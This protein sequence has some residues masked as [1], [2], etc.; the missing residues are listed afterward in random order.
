MFI[1]GWT[2]PLIFI[3]Q[4]HKQYDS[5]RLFS[6]VQN[7]TFTDAMSFKVG[8]FNNILSFHMTM[9]AEHMV[10]NMQ[11]FYEKNKC[12]ETIYTCNC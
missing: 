8:C 7:V 5:E 3:L 9:Q 1:C 4:R 10:H 12:G 6:S 2:I 11:R